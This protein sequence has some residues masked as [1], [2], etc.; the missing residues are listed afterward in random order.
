VVTNVRRWPDQTFPAA[1]QWQAV[2]FMR[3][4]W[5][6]IDG[7]RLRAPYPDALRPTYYTVTKGDL[8]LSLAATFVTSTEL[9]DTRLTTTCS[10]TCS[11]SQ[12]IADGDWAAGW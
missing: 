11:P 8:L 5:P 2:S 7:G 1:L 9:G 4:T 12:A 3:T 10:A 6:N